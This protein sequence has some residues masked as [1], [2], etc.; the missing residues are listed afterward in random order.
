M[1]SAIGGGMGGMPSMDAMRQMQQKMFGKADGNASGGLDAAEFDAMLK[2]G[3]MGETQGGGSRTQELFASLDGDG[4][5]ELSQT[6][7]EDAQKALMEGFRSTMQTFGQGQSSSAGASMPQDVFE[8]LLEA[9]DQGDGDRQAHGVKEKSDGPWQRAQAM[10]DK[11]L[12][13]YGDAG[14]KTQQLSLS[15]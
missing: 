2:N 5:G 9:S 8:A 10:L 14:L 12:A 15:A 3:P 4:N 1:M 13:A 6:E 11:L 7:M